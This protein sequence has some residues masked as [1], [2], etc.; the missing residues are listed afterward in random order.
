MFVRTL[1]QIAQN[2]RRLAAEPTPPQTV[3]PVVQE[4]AAQI[5]AA[6]I[7]LSLAQVDGLRR[8]V[9]QAQTRIAELERELATARGADQTGRVGELA[10]L[11]RS[12]LTIA[13]FAFANLPPSETP[14]WPGKA[15]AEVVG[16]LEQMP[17]F[18][19]DDAVLITEMRLFVADIQ[20][21]ELERARKRGAFVAPPALGEKR[22]PRDPGA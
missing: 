4:P 11:V 22:D 20:Q 17:D 9:Q 19:P 10:Q 15:I 16:R 6:P 5:G 12:L 14:G 18:T 1:R 7:T 13:R 8:M 3:R 21:Y 2:L